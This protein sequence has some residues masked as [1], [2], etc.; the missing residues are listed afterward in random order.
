[1]YDSI[2]CLGGFLQSSVTNIQNIIKFV[3]INQTKV[4]KQ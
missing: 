4:N 3:H 2:K 1:M